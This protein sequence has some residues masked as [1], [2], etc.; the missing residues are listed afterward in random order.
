MLFTTLDGPIIVIPCVSPKNMF[1]KSYLSFCMLSF[2][3]CDG[4]TT[5]S[6]IPLNFLSISSIVVLI[7]SASS[8]FLSLP[9]NSTILFDL[10]MFSSFLILPSPLRF[11]ISVWGTNCIVTIYFLASSNSL[12]YSLSTPFPYFPLIGITSYCGN[13]ACTFFCLN[14]LRSDLFASIRTGMSLAARFPIIVTLTC[15]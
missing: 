3:V 4:F 1:R 9:C 14:L 12:S 2:A 8:S 10:A 15:E 7:S 13:A 6:S 11:S 5:A